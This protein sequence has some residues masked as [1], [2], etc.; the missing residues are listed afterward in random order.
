[1]YRLKV[2]VKKR[3]YTNKYIQPGSSHRHPHSSM[4][5]TL[6]LTL[7]ANTHRPQSLKGTCMSPHLSRSSSVLQPRHKRIK[8][9]RPRR[10]STRSTPRSRSRSRI[11]T[12]TRTRTA[13]SNRST[14]RRV[15]RRVESIVH[16]GDVDVWISGLVS[17]RKTIGR[18]AC[19]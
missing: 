19:A 2:I 8:R 9:E 3:I 18:A 13:L 15:V 1:M 17:A 5:K 4:S 10:N 16:V 7:N 12:R 11:C 14:G 6:H